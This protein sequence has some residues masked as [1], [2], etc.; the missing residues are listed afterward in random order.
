MSYIRRK[1]SLAFVASCV[2][3]FAALFAGCSGDLFLELVPDPNPD[4][5][6]GASAGP[7]RAGKVLIRFRN[8]SQ[9]DA[10]NVEFFVSNNALDT[11]PDD[12]FVD[13]HRTSAN[14]GVAGT[15]ILEPLR[16]DETLFPCTADLVIG[17]TGGTFIDNDTGEVRG[18]GDMRWSQDAAVGLC[19]RSVTF[20]FEPVDDGFTTRMTIGQ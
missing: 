16:S 7:I 2:A 18:R 3:G 17:T 8:F 13:E 20:R 5:T 15:G 14:I 12:L 19:G 9:T 4:P 11:L 1:T 6:P 10:V